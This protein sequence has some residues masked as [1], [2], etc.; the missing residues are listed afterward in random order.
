MESFSTKRQINMQMLKNFLLAIITCYLSFLHAEISSNNNTGRILFLAQQGEHSKALQLYN[1]YFVLVGT[2][3]FELLHQIGLSLVVEGFK[4]RDPES[5]L[6][7]LFG[8]GIAAHEDCYHVIEQGIKNPYPQIQLIALNTIARLQ[9]NTADRALFQALGSSEILI[10]LEAAHQLCLKKHPEAVSQTESLMY[11]VPKETIPLFPP[12]YACVGDEKAIRILRR[13]LNNPSEKVR[14]ATILSLAKYERDDLLP[15]LRQQIFHFNYAQ[16]EAI[17][18]ALGSL[19]DEV[20]LNKLKTL[21]KSQ[22][23]N[24][25]LAAH[26][27][28]FQMGQKEALSYI[29]NAAKEENVFAIAL[30]GEITEGSDTLIALQDS[31]HIQCRMNAALALLEQVNPECLINLSHLLIRNK[32][33][34]AV[35]ELASVGKAFKAW[36][37][38]SSASQVLK[39]DLEAYA[40]NLYF[41]EKILNKASHLPEPHFIKLATALLLNQ[42]NDLIPLLVRLLEDLRTPTAIALLKEYHQKVGAPLVRNYCNLALYRLKEPGPYGDYLKQWVKS[43]NDQALIRFRPFLP[44]Q[45]ETPYQITPEETSRLLIESFEAFSHNQDNAGIEALLDAIE[46]GHSKNKYALAGLLIRATQ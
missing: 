30:L 32:H 13:M 46:K 22:Y 14:I 25:A 43:Q 12:L 44:W 21:S 36:K 31:P 20:S 10:R 27:A 41:R 9:N 45:F 8:A 16:Q 7:A 35:A 18:Y 17:A 28:L 38:I 37:I 11:K 34:L 24:V 33:D 42:Q 1:Q 39:D 40:K 15:Q 2:H 19:K 26:Y 3:D 6:F 29:E 4:Q 23:K 5:Q